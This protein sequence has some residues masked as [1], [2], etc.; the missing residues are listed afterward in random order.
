[1]S[2]QQMRKRCPSARK[3]GV[4]YLPAHKL[5]F[6]RKGSYRDGGVASISS[7]DN[8]ADRVYGVVWALNDEDVQVLDQIEDPEAYTRKTVRVIGDD[9]TEMDCHTYVAIPQA[10][11]VL[12][13]REYLRILLSAAHAE[14]LPA[15]YIKTISTFQHQFPESDET[16]GIRLD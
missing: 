15:E 14:R 3:L 13:D 4:A 7:S 1:M 2:E 8:A 11:Y 9:G 6:N 16:A 10:E 5:V 12:P